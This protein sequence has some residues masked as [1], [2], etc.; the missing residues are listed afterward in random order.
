MATLNEVLFKEDDKTK[1]IVSIFEVSNNPKYKKIYKDKL[2]CP[3]CDN[4]VCIKLYPNGYKT[5]HFAHYPGDKRDCKII[6]NK[7]KN[8]GSWHQLIQSMFKR[9]YR[10]ILIKKDDK[11]VKADIHYKGKTLE[12]QHSNISHTDI[13][14]RENMSYVVWLFDGTINKEKVV[15]KDK[16]E[17]VYIHTINGRNFHDIFT[18]T[19]NNVY[20]H[21]G[22]FLFF[23]LTSKCLWSYNGIPLIKGEVMPL[24]H[25]I[26]DICLND[27][28]D[29][30]PEEL[31]KEFNPKIVDIID[32][33]EF[34]YSDNIN[35][36]TSRCNYVE[37]KDNTTHAS[38][39]EPKIRRFKD[40]DV[41]RL[42]RT[43][44][45][46]KEKN[47][48]FAWIFVY[49]MDFVDKIEYYYNE[50]RKITDKQK[51]VLENMVERWKMPLHD[52][53]NNDIDWYE[54]LD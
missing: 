46:Y 18:Y 51:M 13:E 23:K 27:I 1:Y 48:V 12:I 7:N 17:N 45:N 20:I 16:E 41:Y 38:D 32:V 2:Y 33:K 19:K 25:F 39:N 14:N 6:D 44:K 3:D 28:I 21:L 49:N 40:I 47:E 26:N 54:H 42:I 9:K 11:L 5:N 37:I 52:D 10:E 4:K 31:K 8:E 35:N 24:E 15:Y 50:N 22:N 34:T 29:I 30:I 43:I 36:D 53:D